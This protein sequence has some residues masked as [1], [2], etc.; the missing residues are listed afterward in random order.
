ML[1]KITTETTFKMKAIKFFCLLLFIC[2]SG[3]VIPAN[4]QNRVAPDGVIESEISDNA[5]PPS[6]RD[7][8]SGENADM[9][10]PEITKN[11]SAQNNQTDEY[12]GS[13]GGNYY[14]Q[15]LG[16]NANFLEI[17]HDIIFNQNA[18]GSIDAWVY[19]QSTGVQ[20]IT[21]KGATTAT[22]SFSFFIGSGKLGLR[23]GNNLVSSDDANNFPLN[24]WTHVA[25]TWTSNGG[26]F[27]VKFYID[28]AQS[29]TTQLLTGPMPLNTDKVRIGSSEY[30]SGS[31]SG[32]IDEVRFWNPVITLAM[33]RANRFIGLG[34]D[35]FSNFD[36]SNYDGSSSYTGLL[37][38]YTFNSA[39]LSL[40]FDNIGGHNGI[41]KGAAN[42][43]T[44]SYGNPMPYNNALYF[45]SSGGNDNIVNIRDTTTFNSFITTDGTIEMWVR[46]NSL[47]SATTH[48]ISKGGSSPTNSFL[49]GVNSSGK[50]FFN[51]A[52]NAVTSTGPSIP[53]SD[54]THV[55][56]S[57]ND[58]GSNFLVK[59]FLNGEL[60]DSL[61]L[62]AANLPTNSDPIR[63]GVSQAFPGGLSPVNAYI[64]AIR[65]WNEDLSL[66]SLRR[67]VFAS[68][69]ALEETVTNRLLAAWDFDGTLVPRGRFSTM[70]GTFTTA[71]S[72]TCRFSAYTNEAS[73]TGHVL[74]LDLFG[75]PT[76]I[77]RPGNFGSV[78]PYGSYIHPVFTT[79][80]D[81]DPNGVSDV[82]TVGPSFPDENVNTVELFLSLEGTRVSDISVT[83]TAP[84]GQTRTVVNN[85]GGTNN[86]IL[87]FFFDGATANLT[88]PEFPA[89]W[90]HGVKPSESFGNFGNSQAR[91]NWTIKVSDGSAGVEHTFFGWGI[92]LNGLSTVGIQQTT[93]NIPERFELSQ[94]YP[95][96]F[97]PSTAINFA[98]PKSSLVKLK[99]YDIVGREVATLVNEELSPG[100][101]EYTFDGSQLTSGVYFYR[102]EADGFTEIKKM[103]LVK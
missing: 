103:M 9:I 42:L 23:M 80:P 1:N 43:T 93:S 20:I 63:L 65:I 85:H 52:G 100:A 38:S 21:A 49:L 75:H 41:L 74:D 94:N 29:G 86:N 82:I 76:T 46:F 24:K 79:L 67:F 92:R 54:W 73:V 97:N 51:I 37:A 70:R 101:Y 81:N 14:M 68:S 35:L 45:P 25:V 5:I 36:G 83:L 71:T 57:W 60:N 58:Q 69:S 4:A 55:G 2:V 33:I 7:L 32:F 50:L 19:V 47:P 28:G 64:D 56:V 48:L 26:N 16:A 62:N 27:D 84:N 31:F 18:N 13:V 102:I 44:S 8:V 39:L 11:F 88:S 96:P 90:S 77:K 22:V 53:A 99:V 40:V 17:N 30:N 87:T 3:I 10:S 34:E 91:G 61:I 66:D 59:F 78:F 95:N 6:P 98:L 72:N 12:G 89:P 15:G